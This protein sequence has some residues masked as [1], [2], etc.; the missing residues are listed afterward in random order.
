[1]EPFEFDRIYGIFF[2]LTIPAAAK[3]RFK[4]SVERYV[5]A[6]GGAPR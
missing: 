3:Q 4:A 2:D 1:L 5:A 6:I